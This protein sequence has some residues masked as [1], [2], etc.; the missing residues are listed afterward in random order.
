MSSRQRIDD[1]LVLSAMVRF[2]LLR[3]EAWYVR[4]LS[5]VTKIENDICV[6]KGRQPSPETTGAAWAMNNWAVWRLAERTRLQLEL[7][8]AEASR[9]SAKNSVL[10]ARARRDSVDLMVSRA[11]DKLSRAHERKVLEEIAI[12]AESYIS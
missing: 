3:A 11:K 8:K 5:I 1:L 4:K 2:E 10:E 6:L 7:S 12:M 9:D